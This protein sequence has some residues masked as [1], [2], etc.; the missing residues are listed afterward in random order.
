[1]SVLGFCT[2]KSTA[3]APLRDLMQ[4][5][6]GDLIVTERAAN[7]HVVLCVEDE[8]RFLAH[9]GQHRGQRALRIVRPVQNADRV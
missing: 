6:A 7:S 3:K 1:M 2:E 5:S 9:I 4:M 8:K